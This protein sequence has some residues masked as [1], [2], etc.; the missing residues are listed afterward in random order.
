MIIVRVILVETTRPVRMRPRMETSLVNGHFLS[1]LIHIV[2]IVP[3]KQKSAR[4]DIC[5]I[6]RFGGCLKSKAHILIPTSFLRRHLLSTFPRDDLWSDLS[7][8]TISENRTHHEPS[9]CG[10]A[11]AFGMPF[12]STRSCGRSKV[13]IRDRFPRTCSAIAIAL[14]AWRGE[15]QKLALF[16]GLLSADNSQIGKLILSHTKVN[17]IALRD[18]P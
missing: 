18:L 6:Y 1:I 9:H 3:V 5:S 15:C 2:W 17:Y 10:R 7:W 8:G 14:R 12:Q 16:E 4:T 11:A 13:F